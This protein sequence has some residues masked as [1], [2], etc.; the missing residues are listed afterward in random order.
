MSLIRPLALNDAPEAAR[1]LLDRLQSAFGMVPNLYGVLAHHPP[2]LAAVLQLREAIQT[3]LPPK[4]RELAYLKAS[5]V[6]DCQY[7]LHYHRKMA[8]K[9][10]VAESQVRAIMEDQAAA[11]DFS[12]IESLVVTFA[13]QLTRTTEV[14]CEVLASLSRQLTPAQFVVLTMTVGLANVTNRV[15][16][17]CHVELP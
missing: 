11:G 2:A 3:E 9:A 12:E 8:L 4:L 7:C 1:P 5:A 14:D 16:H 13:D 6:N 10:G 17:A 15:N